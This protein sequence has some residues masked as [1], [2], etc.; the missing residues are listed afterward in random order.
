MFKGLILLIV[1]DIVLGSLASIIDKTIYS[2][3]GIN[4]LLRKFAIIITVITLNFFDTYVYLNWKDYLQLN[5]DILDELNISNLFC[6]L[7][8]CF[9]CLSCLKNLNRLKLPIPAPLQKFLNKLL[10]ELTNESNKY[11]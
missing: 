10:Y 2:T 5:I 11:K 4:G 8:L 7:F 1:L 6:L 9:E 3:I